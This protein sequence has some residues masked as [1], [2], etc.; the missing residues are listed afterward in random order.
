VPQ[1]LD[2]VVDKIESHCTGGLCDQSGALFSFNALKKA[3]F[4]IHWKEISFSILWNYAKHVPSDAVKSG[5]LITSISPVCMVYLINELPFT[6]IN[7]LLP[8]A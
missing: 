7:V 3:F 5:R 1:L 6:M 8:V 2:N 4:S